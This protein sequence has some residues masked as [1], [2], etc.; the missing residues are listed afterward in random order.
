MCS[1]WNDVESRPVYSFSIMTIRSNREVE[2]I[3]DRMPVILTPEHEALWLKSAY[4]ERGQLAE[5]LAP[6]EDGGL[7]IYK[8]S[9]DVNSPRHN[10]KHLVEAV[11]R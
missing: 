11:Q 8:V 7:E 10:D 3:H 2:P 6:Y 5:P 4:S 1:V 9:E